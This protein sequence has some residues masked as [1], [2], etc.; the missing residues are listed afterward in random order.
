MKSNKPLLTIFL[1][2][3]IDLMGFGIIMPLLPYIAERFAASPE[4]I[5]LL[6]ATYSLF[7]FISA[8]IMGRLSDRFGRKKLLMISQFGTF[9]GFVLL[10]VANSLPL[11]FLARIIDGITGGNISIAQAYIADSTDKKDRAKGMGMIGAAFG[12]GFIFGP[13]MGGLLSRFGYSV[14]AFAAAAV[15]LITVIVTGLFLT[16]SLSPSTESKATKQTTWHRYK[17]ILNDTTLLRFIVI[18]LIVNT[19]FS[20]FQSMITLWNQQLFGWGPEKNGILLGTVGVMAAV[21]QLKL[22]PFVVKKWGEFKAILI[23]LPTLAAGFLWLVLMPKEWVAYASN[24]FISAGNSVSGPPIQSLASKE[25]DPT[26]YGEIM[27]IFHSAGSVGRIIGP[28][29]GGA[30]FTKSISLP[31][32]IAFL[33]VMIAAGISS[34]IHQKA[35]K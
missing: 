24:L 7:Q 25:V 5:G 2:V 34:T 23:G 28:I 19:S 35:A 10:G 20:T 26:E 8:P 13:S 4:Q 17:A 9:L 16:E 22:M 30:L 27:G 11:L 1:I 21:F 31:L 29:L 18:F 3:F 12:L 14:P 33:G 32:W 15:S 6:T